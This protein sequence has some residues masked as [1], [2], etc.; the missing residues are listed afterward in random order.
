M[1]KKKLLWVVIP[2]VTLLGVGVAGAGYKHY[3]GYQSP[4][5][6]VEA[7]SEKL[8]LSDEQLEKLEAVKEAIVQG[9]TQMRDDRKDVM[10]QIITEIRKPEIDQAQF[11][12]LIEK[13]MSR[14]GAMATSVLGSIADF[15]KSLND[16][17]RK[18]I[19]NRLE[20]IRDWGRGHGS[21][22]G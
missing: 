11:V 15:H 14:I 6:M 8:E 5:Y 9:R 20:S 19:I 13:R 7:I 3:R 17:Q 10:N 2:I 16:E 1:S 12:A 4:E 21:W 22:H 18:K